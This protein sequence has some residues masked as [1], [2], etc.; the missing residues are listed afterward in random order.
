MPHEQSVFMLCFIG[1]GFMTHRSCGSFLVSSIR[2]SAWQRKG[3]TMRIPKTPVEF[4]Y[5]LWT[6]EDGKCMVRIKRT[7]EVTEVDHEV[8]KILR[9]EEKQLRRSYGSSTEQE[10]DESENPADSILSLD[11]LPDDEVN[12][13]SWLADP[14]DF[15]HDLMFQ[16]L[17][18]DFIRTLTRNQAIVFYHCMWRGESVEEYAREKGIRPQSVRETSYYIRRKAEKFLKKFL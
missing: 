12:S 10:G 13:S 7:G 5:D 4:D 2:C 18:K 15:V 11:A 9:R 1:M 17:V 6:T 16:S 3:R 8:M 14:Y